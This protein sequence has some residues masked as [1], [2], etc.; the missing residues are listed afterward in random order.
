MKATD[1]FK[2]IIKE[3]LDNR[4]AEDELF[5]VS[6]SKEGKS[7]DECINYILQTVKESGMNG[8][9]DDEIFSMAVH[10]YEEDDLGEIKATSG[11][12]I[13][14]HNIELS[15]EEKETAKREAIE[16]YQKQC[17]ADIKAREERA[18]KK[19]AERK[20]EF[21]KRQLTLFDDES[22]E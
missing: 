20:A 11:S 13:V 22:E 12:V 1:E 5:A 10:Y 16:Q 17:I 6:Y 7:I 18:A 9:A 8:F 21:E 2:R 19:L 15:D 4:A 3:H 14:N